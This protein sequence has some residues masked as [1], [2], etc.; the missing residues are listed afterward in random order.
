MRAPHTLAL[1]LLGLATNASAQTIVDPAA[2]PG[3]GVYNTLQEGVDNTFQG[4]TIRMV[5]SLV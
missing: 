5:G 4:G 3:P 2:T 1:G